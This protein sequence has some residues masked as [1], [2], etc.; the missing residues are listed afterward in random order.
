MVWREK[1]WYVGGWLGSNLLGRIWMREEW[2]GKREL[3]EGEF[4]R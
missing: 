1:W 2:V 3:G 4:K